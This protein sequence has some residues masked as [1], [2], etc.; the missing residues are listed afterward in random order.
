MTIDWWTLGLQAV[1]FLILAWLLSRVFWKPVALAITARQE[2]AQ[3]MLSDAKATQ[4][5]ADVALAE[6]EKTRAGM[7]AEREALLAEAGKKAEATAKAALA[8]ASDKA[9]TLVKSAKSARERE[10][11]AM[12]GRNAIDAAELAVDIAGKLLGRLDTGTVQ[13]AFLKLLVETVGRMTPND[14]AALVGTTEGIDM[15]SAVPLDDDARAQVEQ[16][17]GKALGEPPKLNFLTDPDL[18]AGF[19]MRTPH[20][21]LRDSWQSDLA[22]ILKDI[23]NAT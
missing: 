1:N 8:E 18:I 7:G 15:V 20:F 16:A 19:E 12:R 13:A 6:V 17:V 3:T 4:D 11:E 2:A 23:G 14:R 5:K 9:E 21:V 22:A 10:T